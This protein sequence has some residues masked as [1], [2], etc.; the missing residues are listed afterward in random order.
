MQSNPEEKQ[1]EVPPEQQEESKGEGLPDNPDAEEMKEVISGGSNEEKGESQENQDEANQDEAPEVSSKKYTKEETYTMLCFVLRYPSGGHGG[2]AFWDWMIKIYGDSLLEGRNSSGL[3][4]R[5][6]K[7]A[8][9][10]GSRLEEE[11]KKLEESLPKEF[12]DEVEK[13]ITEATVNASKFGLSVKAYS[14]LFPDLPKPVNTKEAE[15]GVKKKKLEDGNAQI[16]PIEESKKIKK[17]KDALHKAKN[18]LDLTQLV[19]KKPIALSNLLEDNVLEARAKMAASKNIVIVKD[20][21]ENTVAIKDVR[22]LLSLDEINSCKKLDSN[23]LDFF[24]SWNQAIAESNKGKGEWTELEDI[25]LRH[26]SNTDLMNIL[27]KTRGPEEIL[28]RK[29][30]LNLP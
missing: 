1:P 12:M 2:E 5:W 10:Y 29:K 30:A 4:N 13:K 15:R 6:R 24:K 27:I 20:M 25:V 18:H 21:K 17:P 22:E 7:L 19:S 28:K 23:L 9:Q 14:T 8:K 3:R 11:K 16:I 26:P